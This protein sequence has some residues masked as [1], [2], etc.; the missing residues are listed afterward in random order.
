MTRKD[1][2]EIER[3]CELNP[4][5]TGARLEK[6]CW[7]IDDFSVKIMVPGENAGWANSLQD[8]RDVVA[9]LCLSSHKED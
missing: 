3:E 1:L 5:L 7:G 4:R 2:E 6:S 9:G 8:F